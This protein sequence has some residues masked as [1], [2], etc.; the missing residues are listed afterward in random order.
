MKSKRNCL[1]QAATYDAGRDAVDI[2][3]WS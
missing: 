3:S 1:A 2:G